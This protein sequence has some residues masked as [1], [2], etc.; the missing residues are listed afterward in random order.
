MKKNLSMLAVLLMSS[1]MIAAC[2][3]P[4]EEPSTPTQT[5]TV[6]DSSTPEVSDTQT[7]TSTPQA[8][9]DYDFTKEVEIEIYTTLSS[10]SGYGLF[11]DD[12]LKIFEGMYDNK[13]KVTPNTIL[14]A[15]PYG[16]CLKAENT[17]PK[18]II[19]IPIVAP[20]I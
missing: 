9:L 7:E 17:T 2:N 19:A 15:I 14:D 16:L 20:T 11:F 6:E 12:A 18:A 4:S 5:P 13:I 3:Q 1:T 10:S 8:T